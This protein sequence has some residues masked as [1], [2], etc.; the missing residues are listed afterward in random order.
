MHGCRKLYRIRIR[1]RMDCCN[2]IC[3]R[4]FEPVVQIIISGGIGMSSDHRQ[5]GF[6]LL[7]AL[8]V[9]AIIAII[10]VA[11]LQAYLSSNSSTVTVFPNAATTMTVRVN[12]DFIP[13]NGSVT[14]SLLVLINS[15]P[16]PVPGTTP[17]STTTLSLPPLTP[18]RQITWTVIFPVGGQ[19][20]VSPGSPILSAAGSVNFTIS[21]TNYEGPAM[22]I[23]T[24]VTSSEAV[25]ISLPVK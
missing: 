3:V 14:G 21:S 13:V 25:V 7:E 19:V 16:N 1:Y 10:G 4:D 5:K 9:I 11:A 8:L 15:P 22:I 20:T 23:G 17:P 24:D 18:G 12:G 6:T 2:D